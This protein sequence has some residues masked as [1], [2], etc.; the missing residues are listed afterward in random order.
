MGEGEFRQSQNG[1]DPEETKL[2]GR[3]KNP[4]HIILSGVLQAEKD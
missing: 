3:K 2:N 4:K 1:G